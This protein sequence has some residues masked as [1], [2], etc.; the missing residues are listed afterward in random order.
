MQISLSILCGSFF[1]PVMASTGQTLMHAR[2]PVQASVSI[3]YVVRAAHAPARHFPSSICSWNSCLK[4][5]ALADASK[6][7]QHAL[8]AYPARYAFSAA[9]CLG[10]LQEE[11]GGIDNAV[12]VIENHHSARSHD[13]TRLHQLFII[14]L[15]IKE[16]LG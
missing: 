8:R 4:Y 13:S 1:S 16:L 12:V 15:G 7:L 14:H 11:A 9:L 6:D 2:Q 5:F 10:E 3:Q